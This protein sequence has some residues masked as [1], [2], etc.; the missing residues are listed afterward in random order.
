M[1][2]RGTKNYSLAKLRAL[3][4]QLKETLCESTA[5]SMEE[6]RLRN[7]EELDT[8]TIHKKRVKVVTAPS[9]SDKGASVPSDSDVSLPASMFDTTLSNSD[10]TDQEQ[11]TGLKSDT[12]FSNGIESDSSEEWMIIT[13]KKTRGRNRKSECLYY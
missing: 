1:W 6:N 12:A 4:N 5:M 8:K 3:L 9:I 2:N 11:A 13:P 7:K 10:G